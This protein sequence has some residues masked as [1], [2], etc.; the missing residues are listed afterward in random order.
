MWTRDP[1]SPH[2]EAGPGPVDILGREHRLGRYLV[3]E[4]RARVG[5]ELITRL[6]SSVVHR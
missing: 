3:R 6:G 4:L 2:E 1:A 5:H